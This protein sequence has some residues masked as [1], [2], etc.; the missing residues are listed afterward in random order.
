MRDKLSICLDNVPVLLFRA[1]V[2]IERFPDHS[3][4][5]I[6]KMIGI[7][8]IDNSG[9]CCKNESGEPHS[10]ISGGLSVL[11]LYKVRFQVPVNSSLAV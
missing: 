7:A 6:T 2:D 5:P 9:H 3:S 10:G 4:V 11:I 8:E 1:T